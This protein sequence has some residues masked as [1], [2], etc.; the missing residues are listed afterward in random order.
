[1]NP[2]SSGAIDFHS[3]GWTPLTPVVVGTTLDVVSSGPF[4]VS[5]SWTPTAAEYALVPQGEAIRVLLTVE[6]RPGC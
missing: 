3:I 1:M 2:R 4:T 5:R 6:G